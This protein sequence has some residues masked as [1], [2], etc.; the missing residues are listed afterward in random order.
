MLNG[1]LLRFALIS[2]V[3]VIVG[4]PDI[5]AAR[6]TIVIGSLVLGYDYWERTYDEAGDGEAAVADDAGDARLWTAGPEIE[7]QSLG[8]HDSL[9]LR[10]APVFRYDD[11]F[12]TTEV[13]HYL[14]V[15]GE[16][17]VT[18]EWKISLSDDFVL[19]DD[20]ARYDTP[21]GSAG[22]TEDGD[23]AVQP[24]EQVPDEITQDFGRR[25]YWTNNLLLE[26]VYA[27]GKDSDAGLGYSNRVL[28]NESDDNRPGAG[29][30]EYDRHEFFGL[31]AHQFN[32]SWRSDAELRYI[33]GLFKGSG[34][35]D[36]L[37]G[38][39][40]DASQDLEE[41]QA[42]L[43]LDYIRNVNNTFP[44]RYRFGQTD[45]EGL[46]RDIWDH[47]LSAGWNHVFDERTRMEL[48][49]G[50]SYI[51]A[52]ELDGEWGFNAYFE[53][54]RAFQ[55]G[56][57]R[58]SANKEYSSRNFTGS[59]DAGLRDM[60]DARVDVTYQFSRDVSSTLFVAYR[61][62]DI[63]DPQGVYYLAA[64]DGRDPGTEQ[65]VGDV[66]YTRESY[67]AGASLD[68]GFLRW[69]VATLRYEYYQQDGD[70][71]RDSY[72]DHRV[73]VLVSASKELWRK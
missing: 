34:E 66:T 3:V 29:Y 12:S 27:Y 52:D 5:G 32:P 65:D 37:E 18:K 67:S 40:L 23:A 36:A 45:Y 2:S 57:I 51:D 15:T 43:G 54:N 58:A 41:Y 19:S 63:I 68:Y 6:Q 22:L 53:V 30:L 44:L 8:I 50:P 59:T 69:F 38:S 70:L 14:A 47:E 62:E 42:G 71:V 13:D 55:H 60:T 17:F 31:L 73:M 7:L 49:G 16:R 20:P 48:G 1:K 39:S 24:V 33:N 11:L 61:Y 10:Y 4:F 21:F 35:S 46:R 26:S 64:L 28:R 72:D 56:N 9:S 25:R